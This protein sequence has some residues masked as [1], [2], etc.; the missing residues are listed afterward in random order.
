[1]TPVDEE[2]RGSYDLDAFVADVQQLIQT[3]PDERTLT[4]AVAAHLC[5]LLAGGLD[6]APEMTLPLAEHYVMRPLHIAADGSFSVACAVWNV[7]QKTP[8]HGH[9]TWGVVGIHSG[10]ERETRYDKPTSPGGP[11]RARSPMEWKAGSVMVCCTADDDV[12]AVECGSDVPCIGIHT[13]GADIGTLRRP[14]YDPQTGAVSWF[15]SHWGNT[16]Q[17]T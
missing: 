12:H 5:A 9:Q 13:Y 15:V 2:S 7:G 8:V 1:M 6:L 17:Q 16:V 11:M 3:E 10:I 4:D 14:S